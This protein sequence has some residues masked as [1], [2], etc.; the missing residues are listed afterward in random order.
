MKY[1][2]PTFL[3]LPVM[4]LY[5][6]IQV[7]GSIGPLNTIALVFLTAIVGFML[8]KSQ[9]FKAITRAKEKLIMGEL[10][11]EEIFT[12]LFLV[13]SG[14]LLITPG[15]VT[16]SIGFFFLIPQVRK[17]LFFII[18]QFITVNPFEKSKPN[19]PNRDW[20]EGEYEKEE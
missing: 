12:G 1:L 18:P 2:L 5:F 4:E 15:F 10:P 19:Q 17:G 8:V 20:I 11:T 6:L 14:V 16:D 7:G 3:V 9:G 13:I